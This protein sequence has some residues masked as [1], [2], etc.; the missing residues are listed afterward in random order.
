MKFTF[1]KFGYIEEGDVELADLTLICGPNNV[2]KTYISY[3]IY[4]F[5]KNFE[6][7]L[8]FKI[9]SNQLKELRET[10]LTQID[11]AQYV[12]Q[13]TNALQ[14]VGDEF[15]RQ[16]GYFFKAPSKFF[17][18]TYVSFINPNFEINFDSYFK[19]GVSFLNE[20]PILL[21]KPANSSVLNIL[22][23]SP[24]LKEF[25]LNI[26][27]Y[28]ITTRLMKYFLSEILFNPF[29][30]TSERTGVALFYKEL[31]S[32]KYALLDKLDQINEK[33]KRDVIDEISKM[34]SR[35]AE[36]IQD[37]IDIIRAY[38]QFN[39]D[40]S[41]LRENT[42]QYT[43]IFDTL[44][45]IIGGG[46]KSDNGQVLYNPKK[47]NNK[48]EFFLPVY[49]ASSSIKSMFLIDYYINHLAKKGQLLVID[50]PEL[51]LHP[52][53]QRKMA[54]LI[55]RLINSGIKIIITTHSEYIVREVNNRIMLSNDLENKAQLME[56]YGFVDMDILK[57]EQVAAY[58]L[59]IDHT[60][61]RM[62]INRYG[63][64]SQ[65]FDEIIA[66][67]NQLSD[68]IYYSIKD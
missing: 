19:G 11:L 13:I 5:L 53:N 36:P 68:D 40:E 67:S 63:I 49:L 54:A 47:E 1:K 43:P 44:E 34:R 37:N 35:Y 59:K 38:D 16:L 32:H 21:E 29:A 39:K 14:K 45:S 52:D 20:N 7:F 56:K 55:V 23:Q 8:D 61:Q 50:E 64:N 24:E 25:P 6:N 17:E 2:S 51:N 42:E 15:S 66:D 22:L 58:S 41:F 48:D 33:N 18:K 28:A 57:P 60:I 4:S 9:P 10:G 27:S 26:L 46:F 31:D 62:D 12:D 3:A 65:I 30:I